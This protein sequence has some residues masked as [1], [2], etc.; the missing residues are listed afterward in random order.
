M[1]GSK[2]NIANLVGKVNASNELMVAVS[3]AGSG[4]TSTV[5][6]AAFAA[7]V[8]AGTAAMGVYEATPS[9]LADGQQGIIALDADRNVKVNIVAGAGAGGT[10]SSFGAAF[11]ATGTA[12]G[13][14]DPDGTMRAMSAETVDYDTGAGS[15]PQTMVG[16]ALPASGGPVAGGTASNP[17]SV[18]GN[19][20]KDG[21]GTRLIPLLDADGH[22]QV[23]VLSSALPSGAATE[24]KQDTQITAEQAIQTAVQIM[25]DWDESDRAKVNLI[26]GQAGIA[27]GTGADGATVPRVTLAT[28]VALPAGTNNIG[29][30]DVASI[31]AGDNTIGRVKIT[32]GTDVVDVLNLTN[33]DPL[34]VAIVDSN[35]DQISSFGGGTQYT[36]DAAAPANPVGTAPVFVRAD[37]PAAVSNTDGDWVAQRATNYGAGYVQVVSSSGAFVDTFGGGTQYN[38]GSASTDTDTGTAALVV[39]KDTPAAATGVADGDRTLLSVSSVGRLW[40][41]A[42]VDAALPAGANIIGKV[43]IDQTTPGTT[44][45]VNVD[46]ATGAGATLGVTTGAAVITDA[47]ATIQQYLRGLVKLAITTANYPGR[48]FPGT[49]QTVINTATDIAAG[50]FSG[51]PSATFDNT[52][53]AAVPYAT[54]ALAMAEFPDWAAAP[55]AGTTVSLYGVFLNTDGTDDDTDAPSGTANGGGYYFGSWIIAAADALQRRTIPIQI[56]AGVTAIDFYIKNETAQNMNNDGG[57]NCVVKI[58]PVGYGPVV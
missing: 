24:A 56:P 18:A 7:G 13:V 40:A 21:S 12:I 23:D 52:S 32:D 29:D 55:V 6:E 19:T 46:T 51:A 16:I 26:V 53:D 33:S 34:A 57:T 54:Q 39:R 5:D 30:V 8:S 11:P 1:A 25:D 50:N 49:A 9:A 43:G 38:Q 31:T 2:N 45:N 14:A 22:S 17:I 47:N 4:G 27:G 58:T 28:N 36:E 44:N 48:A 35:G 42:T 3:G 15:A 10:S 20:V 41:S 37:T